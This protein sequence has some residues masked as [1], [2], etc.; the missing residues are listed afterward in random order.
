MTLIELLVVFA[1]IAVLLALLLPAISAIRSAAARAQS[2]NN[3]RQIALALHSYAAT[4]GDRLPTVDGASPVLHALLPFVEQSVLLDIQSKGATV[5]IPLYLSPADPTAQQAAANR[6]VVTS[7]APNAAVFKRNPSLRT[8]FQDGT[9]NTVVLGEHYGFSCG[10]TSFLPFV[11]QISLGLRRASFADIGDI[12][13]VTR[14]VPPVTNPSFGQVTFQAAPSPEDCQPILP[15]TPH[16]EGMLV[17]LGDGSVRIISPAVTPTTF[18]AAV[19]P[20]AGDTLGSD[21]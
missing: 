7:Y 13:P 15:Q 8:T 14:G 3:L 6:V 16:R 18:W 1:I 2:Q 21:W 5:P 9:S 10:G 19:T 17:A 12:V 20:A 4:N 11:P